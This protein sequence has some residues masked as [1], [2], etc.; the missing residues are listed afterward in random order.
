[1]SSRGAPPADACRLPKAAEFRKY[2]HAPQKAERML[3]SLK[4]LSKGGSIFLSSACSVRACALAE[5]SGGA[6]TSMTLMQG[7]PMLESAWTSRNWCS[8]S[9]YFY[10]R[11]PASGLWRSSL[12][13]RPVPGYTA[14]AISFE[15]Q[16]HLCGTSQRLFSSSCR[17]SDTPKARP[18]L[19][20]KAFEGP[21][22]YAWRQKK[23]HK[24]IDKKRP[25][26]PPR[27]PLPPKHPARIV[28]SEKREHY[29][30]S[31]ITCVFLRMAGS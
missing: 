26:M 19:P 6:G 21:K 12:S 24:K 17:L 25:R 30:Q 16:R 23:W 15:A 31:D 11:R 1:M 3:S 22:R 7:H 18:A 28:Q 29:K 14:S 2:T 27:E 5:Y 8:C 9:F 4:R 13:P 20:V 10:A